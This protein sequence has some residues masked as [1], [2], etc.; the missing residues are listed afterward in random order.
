MFLSLDTHA[1]PS[2]ADASLAVHVAM[3]SAQ[4][5]GKASAQAILASVLIGE[6]CGRRGSC[7]RIPVGISDA[8]KRS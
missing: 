3:A 6:R 4:A 8:V 7:T 5:A 1:G 2:W